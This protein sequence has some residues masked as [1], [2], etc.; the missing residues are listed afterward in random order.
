MPKADSNAPHTIEDA[1]GLLA[2]LRACFG[3]ALADEQDKAAPHS[4]RD[5]EAE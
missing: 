2:E 4:S 3:D 5:P 1:L